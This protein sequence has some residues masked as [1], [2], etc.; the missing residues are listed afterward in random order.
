MTAC[1]A[2]L[3]YF[4]DVVARYCVIEH[5]VQVVEQIDHFERR[6]LRRQLGEADDVRE[7]D[8]HA[9]EHLRRHVAT[10]CQFVGHEPIVHGVT[11]VDS[12]CCAFCST[13]YYKYPMMRG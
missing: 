11:E 2:K 8:R 13:G 10:G 5:R 9:V 1:V 4:V 7:V 3:T 12:C 6:T